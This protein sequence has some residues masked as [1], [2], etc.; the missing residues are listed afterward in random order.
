MLEMERYLLLPVMLIAV[1]SGAVFGQDAQSRHEAITDQSSIEDQLS[2][3]GLIAQSRLAAP[4]LGVDVL[5]RISKSN[6]IKDIERKKALLEEAY[7]AVSNVKNRVRRKIVPFASISV[8]THPGYMSYAYDLKLDALS[9][10]SRIIREMLVLDKDRARQMIFDLNGTLGLKP[11]NCEDALVY[12]V[13][14]IYRT[15]AA[16]GKQAFTRSEIEEGLRALFISNWIEKI[17]SPSQVGPVLSMI[18]E[19]PDF[20]FERSMLYTS[21]SNAIR[22]DFKDDRS[23]TYAL[24]REQV[25][26]MIVRLTSGVEELP[27]IEL[28]SAYRQFISKN[29]AAARCR[30]NEIRDEENIP[31]FIQE[32]NKLFI[33]K[34]F[35]FED[36]ASNDLLESP[37]ISHYWQSEKARRISRELRDIRVAQKDL[38]KDDSIMTEEDWG[39]R[40]RKLL[41]NLNGWNAENEETDS[42]VFNQKCVIYRVLVGMIPDGNLKRNVLQDF[43]RFLHSSKMQRENFIEWFLHV[44]RVAND[45]PTSFFDLITAF[46]NPNFSAV[47]ALKIEKL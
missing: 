20:A 24:D 1:L 18:A 11:L 22:R 4:E 10:K 38:G 37:K 19:F 30:D 43:V 17:E 46:P 14:D 13:T 36:I 21:V 47:A 45:D 23:F 25:N 33:D 8:D 15:V 44:N 3:E 34:P 41:E 39:A 29:I 27:K 31:R 6:K 2:I 16:V 42:E 9:L 7:R 35:T 32:A 40:V 26:S 28:L 12:E 5:L